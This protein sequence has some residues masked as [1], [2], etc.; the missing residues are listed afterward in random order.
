MTFKAATAVDAWRG[1]AACSGIL[2]LVLL[3][4]FW[5][6]N[7][8]VSGFSFVLALLVLV[9]IPLLVYI[10]LRTISTL[11][12]EY[13]VDRDGVT[14]V[15]G[16]MREII[17][18]G[19]IARIQRGG[20]DGVIG[21]W[22]EWPNPYLTAGTASGLGTVHSLAT[23]PAAEQVVLVTDQA[24]YALSPGAGDEFIAAL[25]ARH[26]LGPARLLKPERRWPSV[27]QWTI[28]RD[29]VALLLLGLAALANL[30]V[31]GYLCFRYPQ[32]PANLPLHFDSQGQPDRYGVPAS[33]FILPLIGLGALLINGIWG[34][35]LYQRRR[36][37]SYLLWGGALVVQ[38]LVAVA[39][40]NLARGS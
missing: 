6:A 23:R 19:A 40:V 20:F 10:G 31:F 13:W 12:M 17:P 38:I 35:V 7:R 21:R 2:A 30:L 8:P 26:K 11:F 22:W 39:L 33:L 4:L 27:W 1:V 29:R 3:L 32:L 28:W 14:V 16:P 5:V 24:T 36:T 37:A 9:A 15:W 18:M 34:A 25:Q